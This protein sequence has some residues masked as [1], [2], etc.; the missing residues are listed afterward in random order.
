MI[1]T[2][3]SDVTKILETP[4]VEIFQPLKIIAF[5]T[6]SILMAGVP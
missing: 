6:F 5:T 3:G 1:I 2:L 4:A